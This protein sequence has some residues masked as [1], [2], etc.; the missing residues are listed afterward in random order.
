MKLGIVFF[1]HFVIGRDEKLRPSSFKFQKHT[2]NFNKNQAIAHIYLHRKQI[3]PGT[4]L[5]KL[6]R[7]DVLAN[8]INSSLCLLSS[9]KTPSM[10]L[11]TVLLP[12]F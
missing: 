10:D 3:R 5:H 1:S 9:L 6:G 11:V 4:D 2:N 12:D 7:P 8:C